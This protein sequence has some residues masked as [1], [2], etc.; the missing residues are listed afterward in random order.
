M[1]ILNP[2]RNFTI[3]VNG[4]VFRGKFPLPSQDIDI[5]LAIAR[6]MGGVP[7][8]SFPST[9][10]GY[11]VAVKSLDAVITQKPD[12]FLRRYKSFEEMED[13]EF[14]VE[15]YSQYLEKKTQ[16]IEEGK[17]NRNTGSSKQEPGTGSR[18]VP[19]SEI[20]YAN[21]PRYQ[22]DPRPVSVPEEIHDRGSRDSR[23]FHDIPREA[24]DNPQDSRDRETGSQRMDSQAPSS[25]PGGNGRVHRRDDYSRG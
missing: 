7:L 4:E 3:E 15:L 24:Y 2:D 5:D 10:Y 9:T 16:F 8:D 11:L 22:D 6:R 17:K 14:V 21:Q 12:S 13:T 18:P 23:G 20:Q 1:N 25:Y 19:H